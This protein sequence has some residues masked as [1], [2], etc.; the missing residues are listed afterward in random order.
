MRR[1]YKCICIGYLKV[2]ITCT[3]MAFS[4]GTLNLKTFYLRTT[5][6]NLLISAPAEVFTASSHLL[7]ISA[8]DGTER[9]N[10]YSQ[11]VIITIRWIHGELDEYFLKLW[12]QRHCFLEIMSSIRCIKFIMYWELRLWLFWKS[13]RKR[14]LTWNSTSKKRKVLALS[15]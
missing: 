13:S 5:F 11:M 15:S 9:P 2:L 10:D 12:H 1:R 6:L 3:E 7:N 14:P 8:Q 4:I